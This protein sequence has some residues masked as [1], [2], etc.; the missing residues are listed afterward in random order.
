MIKVWLQQGR[1]L[2]LAL[3]LG[4]LSP[5]LVHAEEAPPGLVKVPLDRRVIDLTATLDSATQERMVHKLEALEQRR[6]AQIAVMLVP[7]LGQQ[8]IE[9]LSNQLFR[10]W[11]L[12]RKGVDDGI[13]L[14]VAKNDHKVRIEVGYGLEPVVTDLLAGQIIAQDLT[15]AFRQGDFAGGIDRALDDLIL[16][17]DGGSLPEPA[18]LAVPLEAYALL[19]AFV[20][21]SVAGVM[22]AAG[23]NWRRVLGGAVVLMAVL[24]GAVGGHEWLAQLFLVPLCMLIGGATFAGLWQA[25]RVFYGVLGLL[26]YIGLLTLV[27]QYL[28]RLTFLYGLAWPAGVLLVLGG[29]WLLYWMMRNSWRKSPRGFLWR[30]AVL[31]TLVLLMGLGVDAWQAAQHWLRVVP[32]AYFLSFILFAGGSGFRW[33]S[34]GGSSSGGRSS[35]G[36]GFSGGG[37]SSGGGG[38][39][40]S[41]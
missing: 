34:G 12:G 1:G 28:G 2:W 39:S 36:G 15:P 9:A 5:A 14:L 16:L 4:L 38:A 6:G 23:W 21:G 29:H 7:N 27:S 19:L 26:L 40:G 3:F 8:S 30:F 13:L 20:F 25:R 18:G 35:S 22:L 33:S 31:L 37:G 41:W 24:V 10:A 32:F 11:K 17:V